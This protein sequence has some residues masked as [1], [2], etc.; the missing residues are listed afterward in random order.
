MY[1]SAG[2]GSF[3]D[4]LANAIAQFEGFNK[5]GSVAQR[6]NNPGNLR[7][8][9]GQTG[10]DAQG[11]AI[12]PDAGTGWAALDHQID[13]NIGRGLTLQEFIGG[14]PGVY[15]GYAPSAD[16]NNVQSYVGF[17]AGQLAIDPNIPLNGVSPGTF[18]VVP[19]HSP[20]VERTPQG[21]S[22]PSST[23]KPD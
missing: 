23:H 9:P 3:T 8:G 17:L 12:F 10:T 14:K 5:A 20:V 15:S 13:V 22:G 7:S 4:S 6:N 21:T 19:P 11:Y 2:L 18:R 1:R 16:S